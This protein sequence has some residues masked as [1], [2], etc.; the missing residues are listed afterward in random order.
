MRIKIINPTTTESF[1]RKNL[2]A[3]LAVASVGKPYSGTVEH[4]SAERHAAAE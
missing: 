3:G 4:L 2:D 1:T